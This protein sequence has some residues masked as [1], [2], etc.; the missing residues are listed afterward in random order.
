MPASGS[1]VK[2]ADFDG[3]GDLDLF[4]GGRAIPGKY[5]FASRSYL[6]SFDKFKYTDVTA[7]IAPD[8]L[9]PGLVT[10]FVWTDFN[11]D[12]QMDLIV[13]GEWMS[14]SFY[15]NEGGKFTNITDQTGTENLKGWWYSIAAADVDKDG[16]LDLICGNLGTNSKFHASHKKPFN[17]FSEDFDKNGTCDIVLSKE[18]NGKLVPT[19]GRQCSSE[20][21]PFIKDKFKTYNEFAHAGL[22]DILGKDNINKALHLQVTDFESKVLINNGDGTYTAKTL[23]SIAQISPINGIIVKDINKDGNLDLI[24]A[25]NMYNAEVETPRYDAGT[26]LIMLG[27]GKGN[28][29]PLKPGASGFYTQENV[30]DIALINQENGKSLIAVAVNNGPLQFFQYDENRLPMK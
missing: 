1:K 12:Q 24:T 10:D 6:L 9:N 4:V 8:L 25:G 15:K 21:M 5:P 3:D 29:E 17:V 19:R 22:D 14:P 30:K 7:E 16:D 26:G 28:F 23:P 2:A 18:Y 20:Q 27:D 11:N 13:V